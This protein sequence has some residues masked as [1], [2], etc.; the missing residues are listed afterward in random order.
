MLGLSGL[1]RH[2][3]RRVKRSWD[4]HNVGAYQ[5]K[6]RSSESGCVV[7][8]P[9]GLL[10]PL[11]VDHWGNRVVLHE[12]HWRRLPLEH[13]GVGS[14]QS[15]G[16]KHERGGR[17]RRQ[18]SRG[19]RARLQHRG[20]RS[21]EQL[22][23]S[24]EDWFLCLLLLLLRL[25]GGGDD[26][27]VVLQHRRGG[28]DGNGWR[29]GLSGERVR[30]EGHW[31]GGDDRRS[32][33]PVECIRHLGGGIVELR[34]GLRSELGLSFW[35]ELLLCRELILWLQCELRL[36][37]WGELE[38]WLVSDK[39]LLS[40]LLLGLRGKFLLWL[41]EILLL[42]L[43]GEMELWL[44]GDKLLLWLGG[45]LLLGWRDKLL[46]RL[47]SEFL[48]RLLGELRLHLLGEL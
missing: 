2:H 7:R 19:S 5:H 22:E 29:L 43:R 45:E 38:L 18:F 36:R 37:L 1:G 32:C 28:G 4:G 15:R 27:S 10:R 46:L 42:G 23:I 11:G 6:G 25:V 47:Q 12:G 39:L 33:R 41:L 35:Y 14:H 26:V 34:P 21:P 24:G 17:W 13:V 40:E 30:F 9:H 44:V 8:V 16:S 31:S 48:L 3:L 20:D